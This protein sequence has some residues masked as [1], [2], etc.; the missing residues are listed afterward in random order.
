MSWRRDLSSTDTLFP[1]SARDSKVVDYPPYPINA[2]SCNSK[3]TYLACISLQP[4][5]HLTECVCSVESR[6]HLPVKVVRQTRVRPLDRPMPLPSQ[7]S[8]VGLAHAVCRN[9]MLQHRLF[10][11]GPLGLL[12]RAASILIRS[13]LVLPVPMS[14]RFRALVLAQ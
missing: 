8:V 7:I 5:V 6:P 9:G 4:P 10:S 2:R 11:C 1:A 14:R 13:F 3:Q 12:C